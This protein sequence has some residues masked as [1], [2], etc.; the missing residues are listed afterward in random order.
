[1]IVRDTES[2]DEELNAIDPISFGSKNNLRASL[3]KGIDLLVELRPCEKRRIARSQTYEECMRSQDN[4]HEGYRDRPASQRQ[5]LILQELQNSKITGA[6]L[7]VV[8]NEGDER[9]MKKMIEI[10][11]KEFTLLQRNNNNS[12]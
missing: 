9:M 8:Y 7:G 4:E 11:E 1:M 3:F 6:R 5:N 10:A 2:V 12:C